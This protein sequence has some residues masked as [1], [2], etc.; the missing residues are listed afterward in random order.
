[1]IESFII[2][3]IGFFA[4]YM[5]LA[6]VLRWV[7][8]VWEMARIPQPDGSRRFSLPMAASVSAFHS[9][10][11]MILASGVLVYFVHAEKWFPPFM[12]GAGLAAVV[13][14]SVVVQMLRYM[15]TKSDA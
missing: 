3:S 14:A 2:G 9:G 1:M 13:F 10:P 5:F 6:A 8:V 11:W 4:G 12:V 15:K 7:A